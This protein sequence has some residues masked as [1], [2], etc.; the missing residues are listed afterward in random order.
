MTPAPLVIAAALLAWGPVRPAP[1]PATPD[2]V[3]DA[4]V[5]PSDS[6]P[7]APETPAKVSPAPA[8]PPAPR[9]AIIAKAPLDVRA[10][11]ALVAAPQPTPRQPLR[12]QWPFWALA[13]GA[14]VGMVIATYVATRPQPQAYRGN[15]PPYYIPFP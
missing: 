1:E 5:A 13:G 2:D 12:K 10:R 9:T 15:A 4:V 11:P 3:G 7:A 14:V 8:P 6:A